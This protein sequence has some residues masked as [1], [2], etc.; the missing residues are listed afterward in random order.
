VVVAC[1]VA[2]C[3]ASASTE[4]RD[5][6]AAEWTAPDVEALRE[7]VEG[8]AGRREAWSAAPELV[9][10]RSVMTFTDADMTAGYVATAETLTADDLTLLQVDLSSALAS[11]TG[12]RFQAFAAVH[13]EA[14]PDGQ[15]AAMFRRGQ[16]VVG[17]FEG[18]QDRAGALGF[19]GRTARAGAITAGAVILDNAFD[20]DSD[21]RRLLRTHE[22]GHALGYNH[23]ESRRSVMN[24]RVGSDLTDFDRSAIEL[25]FLTD[26]PVNQAS[27]TPLRRPR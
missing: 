2:L 23:V 4:A 21:G 12:G 17:R 16:V 10:L 9:I 8:K 27:A 25:A 5:G 26:G 19:G 24:P 3:V 7:L 6:E 15:V 11:L 13:V 14:V 20:R 22:L 1:V 18:V